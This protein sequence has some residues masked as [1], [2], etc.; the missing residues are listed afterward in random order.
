MYVLKT[1]YYS[2]H[3]KSLG[4]ST[5]PSL[6]GTKIEIE[7]IFSEREIKT[8]CPAPA[9]R[10]TMFHDLGIELCTGPKNSKSQQC[11]Q[12][13]AHTP[14][15][16]CWTEDGVLLTFLLRSSGRRSL[17]CR[18]GTFPLA[19]TRQEVLAKLDLKTKFSF[20]HLLFFAVL[21]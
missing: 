14:I 6:E 21:F 7:S 19:A 8:M 18:I 4:F 11:F 9:L 17:D 1:V 2:K 20:R 13:L 3:N 16:G 15:I 10:F 5:C 12:D